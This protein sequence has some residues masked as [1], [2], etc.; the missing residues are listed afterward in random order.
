MDPALHSATGDAFISAAGNVETIV[1][2]P[3]PDLHPLP[4]QSA[5]LDRLFDQVAILSQ[6]SP[7]KEMA[8]L[9]PFFV[10]DYTPGATVLLRRDPNSGKPTIGAANFP[11][12][13]RYG[14]ISTES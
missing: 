7:K 12:W 13:I 5:G 2:S 11:I 14:S 8:V 1:L 3:T 4:A 9:G 6:H 10:G